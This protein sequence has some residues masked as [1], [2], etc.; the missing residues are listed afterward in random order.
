VLK[1]VGHLRFLSSKDSA[2]AWQVDKIDA[3]LGI[4]NI[5]AVTAV[6]LPGA[7]WLMLSALS[8]VLMQATRKSSLAGSNKLP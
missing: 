1:N 3:L 7:F 8:G 5:T 6:P 2:S 4:D